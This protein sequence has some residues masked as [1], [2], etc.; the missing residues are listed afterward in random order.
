MTTTSGLPGLLQQRPH[1]G[2]GV[3]GDEAGVGDPVALGVALRVG[4]RLGDDLQP[5]DL[6]R[7]ARHRQPD[8]ADPAVEV[9]DALARRSSRRTRRRPRRAARPSRCWSGRRRRATSPARSPQ[10]SSRSR[11]SPSTPVGP[12]VPPESPS[13]TVWRSTGGRGKWAGAVTRRVWTCPVRRPSRTTRLRR[14]PCSGAAVVGRDRLAP[15]PFAHL[16]ARRVAALGGQQ[17]VLDVDDQVPAAAR[18]EAEDRR[19]AL[20]R[21][22]PRPR[23]RRRSTRACC[24][25]A[26]ARPPARSPPA[27]SRRGRRSAAAPRRPA[28]A[29]GRAGARR[30]GPARAPRGRA[31][32]SWSA[33]VGD[34]VGAGPQQLDAARLGEAALRLRHLGPHPVA[35]Q[36][37]G[38]EDDAAVRCARR[39]AR[40]RR[41]SRS[42]PRAAR[43]AAAGPPAPHRWPLHLAQ[44]PARPPRGLGRLLA[45]RLGAAADLFAGLLDQPFQFAA[46]ARRSA[47]GRA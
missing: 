5:P 13:I 6:A 16:V 21:P 30:G 12:S 32:R 47:C 37:A 20:A 1:P 11:S 34:A 27:R 31:R 43:R 8:R 26:T 28:P 45:D 14:T 40:R 17:A 44:F 3:A 7:P 29:C 19:R 41:A 23:A 36:R 18:V 10:S 4:D 22:R 42:R 35:R 2:A 38:D 9:E 39:R 33:A 46:A 24:G 15:R 25:S